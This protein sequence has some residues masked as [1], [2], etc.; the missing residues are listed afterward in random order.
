VTQYTLQRCFIRKDRIVPL[1]DEL[2]VEFSWALLQE[3]FVPSGE[4]HAK[5]NLL[6]LKQK[7]FV[8]VVTDRRDP[9]KKNS[10]ILEDRWK[11]GKIGWLLK[12]DPSFPSRVLEVFQVLSLAR[13]VAYE[14][15]PSESG[16]SFQNVA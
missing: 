16:K 2:P 11:S 10:F 14:E 9:K 12:M 6:A 13:D 8:G 3:R 7:M 1:K 5:M 4:R 15:L